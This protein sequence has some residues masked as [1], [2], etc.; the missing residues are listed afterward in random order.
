MQLLTNIVI[1]V[2]VMEIVSSSLGLVQSNLISHF[3]QRLELG[4]VL[5]FGRAILH[6]P[7]FYYES[8]RSGE[9]I[10]RLR[11]IQQI[12]QLISQAV[13]AIPSQLFIATVSFIL[14]LFYSGKLTFFALIIAVLM[15]LSTIA[16]LPILQQK[17]RSFISIRCRKSRC[18]S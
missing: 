3:A 18:F 4:L 6:L 2:V 14:M 8:R 13:V 12:N 9:I 16:F 10:S 11:D 17:T 1:V 7:L 5:E 15:T